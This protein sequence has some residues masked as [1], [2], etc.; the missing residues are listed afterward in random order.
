MFQWKRRDY[1]CGLTALIH[2]DATLSLSAA[3]THPDLFK[4]IQNEAAALLDFFNSPDPLRPDG[5]R[6]LETL[7]DLALSSASDG[8]VDPDHRFQRHQLNR[9]AATILAYPS[10]RLRDLFGDP[11]GYFFAKVRAFI[12]TPEALDR[13]F[14]GHFTRLLE[15]LFQ[16]ADRWL[17]ADGD[18]FM[19]ELIAFLTGHPEILAYAVLLARIASDHSEQLSGVA[20]YGGGGEHALAG[21]FAAIARAA[22]RETLIAHALSAPA[23]PAAPAAG[24]PA[25]ACAPLNVD[26][27]EIPAHSPSPFFAGRS[28]VLEERARADRDRKLGAWRTKLGACP[29]AGDTAEDANL[30][31]YLLLFALHVV[32]T[33][34]A[35]AYLAALCPAAG[36]WHAATV[37][38]LY[39]CAVFGGPST[40]ATGQAFRLLDAL[41][42]RGNDGGPLPPDGRL[43]ALRRRFASWFLFGSVPTPQMA[44]ALPF[45]GDIPGNL[46]PDPG[47]ETVRFTHKCP[48]DDIEVEFNSADPAVYPLVFCGH[49]LLEEPPKNDRMNNELLA[50]LRRLEDKRRRHLESV[51]E[52]AFGPL[53]ASA[54]QDAYR[55]WQALFDAEK[56]DYF[57]VLFLITMPDPASGVGMDPSDER[58]VK[59]TDPHRAPLNG[60]AREYTR[61]RLRSPFFRLGAGRV[62]ELKA[63]FEVFL[64]QHFSRSDEISGDA[65]LQICRTD[66]ISTDFHRG[67]ELADDVP[68]PVSRKELQSSMRTAE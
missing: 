55:P 14:A 34:T 19:G 57:F 11:S 24:A 32:V 41:L 26:G 37:K 56:M 29:R 65:A 64:S 33:E 48:H 52:A 44:A 68:G 3:I 59:S 30:R 16:I 54:S 12:G 22:A 5:L 60:H 6:R 58:L 66:D 51:T 49:F 28:F 40:M 61:M 31:A 21:Y 25:R 35:D 67:I 8:L 39:I 9:N 62:S 43:E 13:G 15:A 4:A 50:F 53:C 18:P 17:R 27:R 42:H 36:R 63:H 10:R 38:C 47:R 2:A 20:E 23:G 1:E 46:P 7:V 45:F